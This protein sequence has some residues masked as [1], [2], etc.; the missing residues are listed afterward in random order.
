MEM[1]PTRWVGSGFGATKAFIKV[2]CT[3]GCRD[4]SIRPAVRR[5]AIQWCDTSILREKDPR[6]P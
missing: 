6:T 5:E 4:Q 2:W 3:S 1:S